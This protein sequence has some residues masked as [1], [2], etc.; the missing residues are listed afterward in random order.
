MVQSAVRNGSEMT[1]GGEDDISN[2][3]Q[4]GELWGRANNFQAG[5][6]V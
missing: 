5:M 6:A 4:K 1:I 3:F 2:C